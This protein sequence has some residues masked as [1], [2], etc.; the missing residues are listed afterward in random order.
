MGF[1]FLFDF[2]QILYLYMNNYISEDVMSKENEIFD[3]KTFQDLTKDIY[4]N[5]QKK[6]LQKKYTDSLQQ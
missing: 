1:L 5:S 6:K 3:G 2:L 4:E